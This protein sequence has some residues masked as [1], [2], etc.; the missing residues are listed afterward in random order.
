MTHY[1][2]KRFALA[3]D[4]ADLARITSIV[5]F[6]IAGLIILYFLVY[7][8]IDFKGIWLLRS[9]DSYCMTHTA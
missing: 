3:D 1:I 2:Q 4:R 6:N 9:R 8:L 5:G 7:F